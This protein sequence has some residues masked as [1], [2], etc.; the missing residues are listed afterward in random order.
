VRSS[1]R[2][3]GRVS[4]GASACSLSDQGLAPCTPPVS[5]A[6]I[7]H[8]IGPDSHSA[9]GLPPL[10]SAISYVESA[11]VRQGSKTPVTSALRQAAGVKSLTVRGGNDDARAGGC[12]RA[13]GKLPWDP[14]DQGGMPL[15][16]HL[17]RIPKGVSE[18]NYGAKNQSL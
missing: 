6:S 17:K 1:L 18:K 9:F 8:P 16:P 13:L 3:S 2:R 15:M 14:A 10:F 7:Q 4:R 5:D 12:F 11:Q